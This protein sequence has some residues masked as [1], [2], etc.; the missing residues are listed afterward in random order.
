MHRREFIKASAAFGASML[1][2]QEGDAMTGTHD[3]HSAEIASASALQLWYDRPAAQWLEALPLGNGR[4]GMMIYGG[5]E[6]ET[7]ALNEGTLWAGGPH[8]YDNPEAL[9]A[10]PEIR[11]LLLA[12][13]WKAAQDLVN[14]HFMSRPLRQAPYQTVGHLHLEFPGS[15][16]GSIRSNTA[17][18]ATGYRRQLNL[19][20]ALATV[21]YTRD[22]VTYTR[23][24]FASVPDQLL[25]VRLTASQPGKISF[26]ATFASPQKSTVQAEGEGAATLLVLDGISGGTEGRPGQVR[27]QA[28]VQAQAE[29]GRTHTADGALLV[30]GANAVTLLISIATS[31]HNYQDVGGDPAKQAQQHLTAALHKPY[32]ALRK[33]HL[34]DYQPRFR[35]FT[36]DLGASTGAQRPTDARVQSFAA[37]HDPGLVALYCQYGRYLL[38]S[39]S[40]PGGQPATLQGLWNDS[41]TPPWDSKYTININTEMNYWLA[42]PGNLLETYEPLFTMLGEMAETGAHTA[43]TH[44]GADGWVCHHNTDGWRGTAPIDGATWGMWPLGGG[45]LSLAIWDHYTYTGDKKAL[46]RHYPLLRGAAEFFLNSLIEEPT[47]KWLVTAPSNSPEHEH[48]PGVSVCYG[49]TM[50]TQILRD[51]FEAVEKSTEILGQDGDLRAKLRAARG[52]LAPMHIGAQGQLQEWLEDWDGNAP[53]PHHRHVSHLYGCYPSQQITRRTTPD[54]FAATRRTLEIR[55]DESTGWAMAWRINLWARLEDGEHAYKLITGL[56]TPAKTA[57]NL[58]DLHPPFQIDGN[59]G[60]AA[61]V[62]EMLL[63]SHSNELHILPALPSAWPTGQIHGIR[64]RGGYE[65]SLQWANSTLTQATITAHQDTQ[66]TLRLGEKTHTFPAKAGHRYTVGPDLK[67][68]G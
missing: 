58:F 14:A 5:V 48:H 66:C 22:G 8:S 16:F 19:D 1:L 12:K 25:V 27:F 53:D 31:Y 9:A 10:L 57:P 18:T 64:A 47:H 37:D 35:R 62:L 51:L 45:W 15:A 42:G 52:R 17:Q 67:V 46:A 43:K 6:K 60:G 20:S 7:L 33:A 36:I 39:C 28:R 44:Y 41:L 13:Q 40:R 68:Q 59:F 38:L 30:E 50:D 61:G 65:V 54:L 56:L 24:M 23:E 4:L 2:P 49:P 11:R 3:L 21:T 32:D 29:G 34:A 63:Q 55:G 26:R